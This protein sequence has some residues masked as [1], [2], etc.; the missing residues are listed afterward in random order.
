MTKECKD[1][2]CELYG[3]SC[4]NYDDIEDDYDIERLEDI[5]KICEFLIKTK[6]H[7]IEKR[8][9]FD[10]LFKDYQEKDESE[11]KGETVTQTIRIPYYVYP[12]RYDPYRR[13]TL[14]WWDKV[15]F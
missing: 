1:D 15:W 14:P 7:R 9:T 5:I 2:C 4:C 8:K 13:S 3:E 12:Y 11:K 6:K 10:K